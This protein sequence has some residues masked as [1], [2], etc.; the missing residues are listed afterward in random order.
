MLL[1]SSDNNKHNVNEAK[2]VNKDSPI[3]YSQS[4]MPVIT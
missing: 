3:G 2:S 1:A 4:R